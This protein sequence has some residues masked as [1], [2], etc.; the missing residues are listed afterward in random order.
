VT[1]ETGRAASERISN[2]SI[3]HRISAVDR[4]VELIRDLIA[5]RRL[6]IGDALPTERELGELFTAS[7][8]TVRE[9]LQVLRAYGIIETR[10]KVGAVISSGHG[11]AIRKL[12]S[13]Q[14]GISP[15]SFRDVQG[16]RRIIEI[17]VGD[18]VILS[19]TDQDFEMLEKKNERMLNAQSVDDGARLDY[20]F[21]EAIVSLSGNRTT[22]AAYRMFRSVIEELM[23]LGKAN[24][25][26]QH[27]SCEVHAEIIGA[28]R[29]RDRLA[30][31]YLMSKHLEFALRFVGRD[32]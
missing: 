31:A 7:R 14:R 22:L 5:K 29:K 28:L 6:Q 9:A 18:Q 3:G 24:R 19:A 26:V 30:Y 4:L 17:G 32:N 25:K 13:F 10:P 1:T 2:G 16:F 12:L 11:E 15:E 21:H 8:N 20:E 27:E 23:H